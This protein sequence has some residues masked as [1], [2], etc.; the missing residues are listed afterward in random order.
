M[1]LSEHHA[2]SLIVALCA[3]ARVRAEGPLPSTLGVGLDAGGVIGSGR[4]SFRLPEVHDLDGAQRLRAHPFT[5]GRDILF[6]CP[7][8]E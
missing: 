3:R 6:D 1:P 5:L 2:W 8:H 7:L 4:P